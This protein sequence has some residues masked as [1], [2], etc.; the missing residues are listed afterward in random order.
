MKLKFV[1][2]IS[3]ILFSNFCIASCLDNFKKMGFQNI[4]E[5]K[6]CSLNWKQT[7][8]SYTAQV[9]FL[10]NGCSKFEGSE[11][12]DCYHVI[13]CVDDSE[14]SISI[15]VFKDKTYTNSYCEYSKPES[16]VVL[17][18]SDVN[19]TSI[20]TAIVSCNQKEAESIILRSPKNVTKTCKL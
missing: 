2:L 17:G 1:A 11:A 14:P 6:T 7:D 10:Q 12:E 4:V 19:D 3:S 8:G 20:F 9:V 15:P 16:R 5:S 13:Y 18:S